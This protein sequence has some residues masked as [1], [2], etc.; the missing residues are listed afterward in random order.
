MILFNQLSKQSVPS[1]W[2]AGYV[3]FSA[4]CAH[5]TPREI[6]GRQMSVSNNN[7]SLKYSQERPVILK[8]K[9]TSQQTASLF[10]SVFLKM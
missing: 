3:S 10:E 4:Q 9:L 1:R 5:Y 6:S 2:N 7:E 8:Q